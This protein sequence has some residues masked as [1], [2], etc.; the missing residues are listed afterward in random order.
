[1]VLADYGADVLRIDRP[2]AVYG[3]DDTLCRRKRSV[4]IDL[5]NPSSAAALFPLID[6]ADVLIEPYRPGVMERLGLGPK[7][8][9]KRNPRLIYARMTGFRR[10]GVY[11][12]S[13]GHD[14]NYVAVSGLLSL[15]GRKGEA[16]LPPVNVL[17][18]FGGGGLVCV[19]GILL[20]LLSRGVTGNGQVVEAN[21]V[22][23][24]AYLATQARQ[25]MKTENWRRPRGENL[26]DGGSPFY[27][28][29]EAKDGLFVAVGSQEP[30]FY[31]E[32]LDGLGFKSEEIPDRDDRHNWP[33]LK[34]IFRD[35][36]KTRTQAEWK[37]VFDGTDACVTPVARM[38]EVEQPYAPLVGLS[39]SPS[40]D[41]SAQEE[42]PTLE[43]G[44]GCE[45][46][47]SDWLG[48]RAREFDVSKS[49]LV[50]YVRQKSRL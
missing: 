33:A 21:M 13:A 32:L 49:N 16:P 30:Q 25:H 26:L 39:E 48:V 11:K 8:L 20:A 27:D 43:R 24:T 29:Y 41:V 2:T 45:S 38:Q 10:T 7:E 18:D 34:K 4:V 9:L 31:K 5:K 22:D 14:L 40:L 3:P 1:M 50:T 23:G 42:Y 28:V 35:R 36:I 47:L 37:E 15:I 17:G 6:V 46:A 44:E 12:D 19:V